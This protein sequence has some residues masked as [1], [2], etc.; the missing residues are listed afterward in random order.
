M[1][2]RQLGKTDLRVSA[3]CLGTMTWGQQNSQDEGFEQMDHAVEAGINFMDAAEM[4]PVPPTAETQGRTEEILGN[5]LKARGNRD[6]IVVATKITG[7]GTN[8]PYLRDGETRLDAKSIATAV[9]DSL[10]RLQTDRID[11]YQT[12]WPDRKT[13]YFGKLGYRHDADDVEVPLEETLG[14]LGDLVKAGKIRHVGLS[15]DTPW[16]VMRMLEIADRERLPRVV[17]I[18]NPYNLLNRTFEIGLAEIAMREDVGLMAYSP[19]AGGTLSGKYLDGAKPEG[20]R[21]TLFADRY[22]RYFTPNAE[23]AVRAYVEVA[24]K[25][26]L[27]P[28]EMA[29]AFV[30]RQPFVTCTII[31]ETKMEQLKSNLSAANLTLSDEVIKDIE[32][33]QTRIQNPCP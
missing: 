9:E 19:L 30:H 18:Q 11:L 6:D 12:H 28:A 22:T 26:G 20:S 7:R 3:I 8:F 24:K 21:M 33:V 4:Y 16:G 2:Y 31:G 10:K 17:S 5:W 14:A 32:G 1:D 23:P 15:N 27:D 29:I 13:N 25:H